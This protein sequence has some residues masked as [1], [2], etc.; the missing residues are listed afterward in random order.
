MVERQVERVQ[1]H[2]KNPCPGK[3]VPRSVPHTDHE[4]IDV[5]RLQLPA[6]LIELIAIADRSD[7]DP[8]P[9]IGVSRHRF[10]RV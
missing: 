7:A 9:D 8:V 2:A 3:C 1:I 10:L 5:R 4:R 6:Q